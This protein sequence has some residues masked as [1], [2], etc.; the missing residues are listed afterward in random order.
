MK[1]VLNKKYGGFGLSIATMK[2]YLNKKGIK[3]YVYY[4]KD[5][6]ENDKSIWYREDNEKAKELYDY[7]NGFYTLKNIDWGL[8]KVLDVSR[9]SVEDHSEFYESTFTPK[10]DRTDKDLIEIIETLGESASRE[11]SRLK[12]VEIPDDVYYFIDDY[13]GIESII[14]SKEKMYN[15]YNEELGRK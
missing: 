11:T 12:I 15:E 5:G 13:D 9:T 6:F 2:L 3:C 14:Y 10:I 1:I 7:K 8:E 4:K